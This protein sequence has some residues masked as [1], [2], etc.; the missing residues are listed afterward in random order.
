MKKE[1]TGGTTN[2]VKTEGPIMFATLFVSRAAIKLTHARLAVPFSRKKSQ[3][4]QNKY[5]K[6]KKLKEVAMQYQ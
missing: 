3:K 6:Y 4:T 1:E 5:K 2:G